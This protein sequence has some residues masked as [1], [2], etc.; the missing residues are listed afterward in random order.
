[1][2]QNVSCKCRWDINDD[3]SQCCKKRG[4]PSYETCACQHCKTRLMDNAEGKPN[5]QVGQGVQCKEVES[6]VWNEPRHPEE[7]RIGREQLQGSIAEVGDIGFLDFSSFTGIEQKGA[8]SYKLVYRATYN[9]PKA[10]ATAVA[11]LQIRESGSQ[12]TMQ[13]ALQEIKVFHEL[14][15]HDNLLRLCGLTVE[16]EVGDICLVTEYAPRGSLDQVLSTAHDNNVICSPLVQ[17][18]AAAQICNGMAHLAL[19]QVVHRDLAARN[20]LVF[21]WD[22]NDQTSIHL[23]IA[24]YGLAVMASKGYGKGATVST[25]GSV[26]RPIRWMAPESITRRQYSEKSDVWAFG[27]TMWEIWTYC[28]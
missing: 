16:P 3:L 15:L 6:K 8:G 25:A 10:G 18:A 1:M 24:D 17:L 2:E 9:H 14:G 27:V 12:V 21:S 26:A 19:H 7:E 28:Q 22:H 20:V 13:K 5:L 11:L 23:K 4:W